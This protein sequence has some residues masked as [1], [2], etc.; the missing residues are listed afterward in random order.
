MNAIQKASDVLGSQRALSDALDVTPATVN[1]WASGIR[2]V[3]IE[4]C[5][6]IELATAGEVTRRDLR[7]NDW[8]LI[9]PELVTEEF[10]VPES[11]PP[12]EA[13]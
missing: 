12:K 1:Q 9:W 8:W 11:S 3:P 6:A 5:P 7:P 13:A 10:K 4:R 2:P